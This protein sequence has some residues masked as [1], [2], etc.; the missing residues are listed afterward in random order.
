MRH[1]V[2]GKTLDRA[3][4]PR[5]LMLKNL[6]SSIIIYEK[7]KTTEAK[8]KAVRTLLEN[9]IAV[10]IKGGLNARRE[11]IRLLPQPMAIKKALDILAV[12]YKG[13]RGGYLRITKLA[14]RQGDNAKIV[15]IE[16]V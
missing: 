7:V 3:K 9:A 16:L 12:K 8:A 1:R 2:K 15:Q 6:A 4:A 10:A 13:K 5:E 11:L 14:Q